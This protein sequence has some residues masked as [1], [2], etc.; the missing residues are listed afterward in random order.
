MCIRDSL[1]GTRFEEFRH[2]RQAA[3]DVPRLGRFLRQAREH[4][5]NGN[6]LPVEDIDDRAHLERDG[7]RVI[8]AMHLHF[9]TRGIEKSHLRTQALARSL[10][11][12]LRIDDHER[13]Q[14]G[15][16]VDLLG[17]GDAF[18]DILEL[19]QTRVPVSYTHLDVYK[20]QP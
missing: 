6:L 18:L 20:R 1:G 12:P 14:P 19:H 9:V 7:H 11:A 8:A 3:G 2:T 10:A 4:V 15:Y 13:R 17:D 5:A 16:L